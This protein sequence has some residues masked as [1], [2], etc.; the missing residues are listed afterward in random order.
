MERVGPGGV[1][2]VMADLAVATQ[3]VVDEGGA[4]EKDSMVREETG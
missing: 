2:W 4:E 1:M 3:G